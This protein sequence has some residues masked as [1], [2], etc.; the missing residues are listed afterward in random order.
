MMGFLFSHRVNFDGSRNFV[1]TTLAME[2]NSLIIGNF[3]FR[4]HHLKFQMLL[5][6]T[7]SGTC[8]T[9]CEKPDFD[10]KRLYSS[11]V[12]ATDLYTT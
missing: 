4:E 7:V 3:I 5:R 11:S 9:K 12:S 8:L 6:D 10:V 2:N 1:V